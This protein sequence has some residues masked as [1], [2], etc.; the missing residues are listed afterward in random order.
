MRTGEKDIKVTYAREEERNGVF[1][2]LLSWRTKIIR[3]A[4]RGAEFEEGRNSVK[5]IKPRKRERKRG[6]DVREGF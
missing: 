1:F 3:G 4:R 5:E 6:G 2:F